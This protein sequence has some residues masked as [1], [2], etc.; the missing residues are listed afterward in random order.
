MQKN[1]KYHVPNLCRA[2]DILEF[3]AKNPGGQ[4]ISEIAAALTF[5]KNSVFRIVSTMEDAGYLMRDETRRY[6]LSR[7]LLILGYA[8]IDESSLMEKALDPMRILRDKTRQ[9]VQ[10]G[11]LVG[12]E[13]IVLEQVPSREMIRFMVNPGTR[14]PLHCSAPG[15]A[16]LAFLPEPE[17]KSLLSRITFT[18]FNVRTIISRSAFEK[19]LATVKKRGYALDNKEQFSSISCVGAPVFNMHGHPIAAIWVSGLVDNMPHKSSVAN[20]GSAVLECVQQVSRHLGYY[21][22]SKDM[23]NK[24]GDTIHHHEKQTQVLR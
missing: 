15:K 21:T 13:G 1:N 22:A 12:T 18:R 4:S 19:E 2:L 11:T 10:I 6:F 24:K 7:K 20:M 14:F 3:L 23:N 17:Q 8:S 9:T 16:I 5:P